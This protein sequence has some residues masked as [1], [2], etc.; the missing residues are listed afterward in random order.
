MKAQQVRIEIIRI[1][2]SYERSIRHYTAKVELDRP[3]VADAIW[4]AVWS[5]RVEV[6]E[7]YDLLVMRLNTAKFAR[8]AEEM[9]LVSHPSSPTQ[10]EDSAD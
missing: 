7:A 10:E 3:E 5:F 8:E 2:D 4:D 6:M 9:A 1:L